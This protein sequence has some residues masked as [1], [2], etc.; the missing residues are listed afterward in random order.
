MR[1]VSALCA[2]HLVADAL[3][4]W[5]GYYWLG[6]GESRT[7]SVAW[8]GAVALVLLLLICLIHG[9]AFVFF[10]DKESRAVGLASKTALRNLFPLT[11]AAIAALIVYLLLALWL[12]NS[13]GQAFTIASYLTLT[14]RK[15][16]PP[17]SVS[18]VFG[19]VAL[20]IRWVL[21]PV[22]LA[23]MFAKIAREGW[24]GF[25]QIGSSLKKWSLWIT[26]PACLVLS[27]WVPYKLMSWV[28]TITGFI[29]QAASLAF[30]AAVAYLFFVAGW[31]ALA[32]ATSAGSPRETHVST[33]PSP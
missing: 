19:I 6:I 21:L 4:L 16:I 5:L 11:M 17:E 3:A 30:R 26:V 10:S 28:P 8:S 7:S 23:P 31:L 32:F 9:A 22:L 12:N 1:G 13:F 18:K 14:L 24:R 33:V 25:S 29:F 15:P 20:V 2:T 27:L